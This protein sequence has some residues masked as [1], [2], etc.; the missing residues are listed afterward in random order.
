MGNN[1]KEQSRQFTAWITGEG[2]YDRVK[3]AQLE[4][5]EKKKLRKI[6][7]EIQR[8]LER[9]GTHIVEIELTK[10]Q[11]EELLYVAFKPTRKQLLTKR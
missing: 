4:L 11:E 7:K 3:A 6:E 5:A 2:N 1:E 9:G 10:K 8:R